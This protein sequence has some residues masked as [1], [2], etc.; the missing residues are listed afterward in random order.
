MLR[1]MLES[2]I[3]E[4]GGKGAKSFRK[5]LDTPTITAIETFLRSSYFYPYL[6]KF[7]E[8]LRECNDLS[9]LWYR[10]FFLEMTMGKRIQVK[11]VPYSFDFKFL[12]FQK[13][14]ISYKHVNP[15]FDYGKFDLSIRACYN[16]CCDIFN[17]MA[18]YEVITS[19]FLI[20]GNIRLRHL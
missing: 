5:D 19:Y 9:Q 7:S 3:S 4:R 8:V 20:S 2:L 11:F 18:L 1:T 16:L 17:I 12:N 15:L 10:E 6:L 14:I 13:F